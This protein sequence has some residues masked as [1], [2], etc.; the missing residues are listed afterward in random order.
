MHSDDFQDELTSTLVTRPLIEQ[1]KGVLV[2]ARCA[3]P[4]QALDELRAV[5]HAH[6]VRLR[7]LACALVSTASGRTPRDPEL[8]KVVWHA[9]GRMLQ[10]C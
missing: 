10:N 7:E 2:M 4:E 8:R 9:W 1:A 5:S 3:T 6:D